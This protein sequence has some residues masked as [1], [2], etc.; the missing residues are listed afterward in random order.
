MRGFLFISVVIAICLLATDALFAGGRYRGE[1]WK[2]FSMQITDFSR[3]AKD[4]A[5]GFIS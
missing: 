1:M 2:G 4:V 5:L 3:S